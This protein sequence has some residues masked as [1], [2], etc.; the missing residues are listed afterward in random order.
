M[1]AP[2]ESIS[3]R[4]MPSASRAVMK[5]RADR[6]LHR[7]RLPSCGSRQSDLLDARALQLVDHREISCAETAASI[8]IRSDLSVR[9]RIACL[10]LSASTPSRTGSSPICTK[11]RCWKSAG[12]RHVH[13]LRVD[14][15]GAPRLRQ[16]DVEALLHHRR[17]HHE[18]DQQHQHDVHERDDVDLG[19]RGGD[20]RA[21]AAAAR[22]MAPF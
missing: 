22:P 11:R 8:R 18:D 17:G 14:R 16:V 21:T 2:I 10:T 20:P 1:C 12:N 19:E 9:G 7:Y 6:F 5:N 4:L 13:G 3:M 15:I